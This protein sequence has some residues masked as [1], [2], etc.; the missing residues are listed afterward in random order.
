MAT[1]NPTLESD[2]MRLKQAAGY[3]NIHRTTLHDLSERD[4]SFPRKIKAGA[5]LCYFRKSELDAWLASREM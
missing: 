4:P 2:L 1:S 3:L 5:R